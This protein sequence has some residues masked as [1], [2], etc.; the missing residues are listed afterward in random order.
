MNPTSATGFNPGVRSNSGFKAPSEDMAKIIEADKQTLAE[1]GITFEQMI[2]GMKQAQGVTAHPKATKLDGST[3]L[4]RKNG[5]CKDR[6]PSTELLELV[7]QYP[8][9]EYG[10]MVYWHLFDKYIV[11]SRPYLG[12]QIC[13]FG[14]ATGTAVDFFVMNQET[15]HSM[16][17]SGMMPHLIREHSF[18]EGHVTYRVDPI[19]AA[20]VFGLPT[21]PTVTELNQLWQEK[22]ARLSESADPVIRDFAT[23]HRN[24]NYLEQA[25]RLLN[26]GSATSSLTT[27]DKKAMKLYFAQKNKRR[28]QKP[29]ST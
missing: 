11:G 8:D 21:R 14:C 22:L 23:Y 19:H 18:F 17:Y 2:D 28:D 6:K 9:L 13:P 4:L 16:L 5:L 7:R 20:L 3:L 27:T 26:I 15:N 29:T 24:G 10:Q 25:H 1:L 12:T